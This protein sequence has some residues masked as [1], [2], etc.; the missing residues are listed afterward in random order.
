MSLHTSSPVRHTVSGKNRFTSNSCW[1]QKDL[2]AFYCH[3]S[4]SLRKPL[5]PADPNAH[6]SI[7]CVK[8]LKTGISRRKIKFFLIEM[9]IRNMGLSVNAQNRTVCIDHS[10]RIKQPVHISF[11]KTYRDHYSKA[12]TDSLEI[13]HCRIFHYR[14]C[15]LV[16]IISALLAEI[17]TFKQLWKKD[18]LSSFRCCLTYQSLCFF[19]VFCYISAA[20]HLD[21]GTSYV[22]QF[23]FL[24]LSL[25]PIFPNPFDPLFFQHFIMFH[26]FLFSLATFAVTAGCRILLST[27]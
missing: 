21:C 19:Y 23:S 17:L 9:V 10:N 6:F 11:V 4:G 5:V 25:D 13:S 16:I 24:L 7:G 18:H 27:A 3:S 14:R 20:A 12:C 15:K 8:Y 1:I 22:S 2:C 26:P